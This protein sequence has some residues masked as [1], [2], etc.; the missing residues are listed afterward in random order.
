ML[1]RVHFYGIL[2]LKNCKTKYKKK[3]KVKFKKSAFRLFKMVICTI[4]S[5]SALMKLRLI[6]W[7]KL[8][9]NMKSFT[10]ETWNFFLQKVLGLLKLNLAKTVWVLQILSQK[11]CLNFWM[12]ELWALENHILVNML[13]CSSYISQRYIK[14]TLEHSSKPLSYLIS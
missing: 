3:R 14:Y 9:W 13:L 11:S 7:Y 12:T 1:I 8:N 4:S 5:E 2:L 10:N 6:L